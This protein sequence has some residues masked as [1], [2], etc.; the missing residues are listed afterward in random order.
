MKVFIVASGLPYAGFKNAVRAAQLYSGCEVIAL[1]DLGFT[2]TDYYPLEPYRETISRL[3]TFWNKSGLGWWCLRVISRW[4]AIYDFMR[5][6]KLDGPIFSADWDVLIFQNLNECYQPF[7]NFDVTHMGLG[8]SEP[9]GVKHPEIIKEYLDH[10]SNRAAHEPTLTNTL[11]GMSAW[12]HFL[13]LRA[14]LNC[15]NLN[16]IVNDSIFDRNIH[17]DTDT[18]EGDGSNKRIFW[19]DKKPYFKRIADEKMIRANIIHC[20][21]DYKDKTDQVLEQSL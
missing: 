10:I 17:C 18:F 12:G 11:N 4:A 13:W 16:Q 7:I 9:Y 2:G 5:V 3:E 20:W 8:W 15:G 1:N 19:I 6:N 21:G 14:D